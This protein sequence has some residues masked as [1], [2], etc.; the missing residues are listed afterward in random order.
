MSERVRV[1]VVGGGITGLAAALRL[2]ETLGAGEVRLL[3]SENRAG[4]K[5]TTDRVDGLVIEGGPDCFLAMKP[6]GMSLCHDLGLDE[7]VRGTNPAYRRTYIQRRGQLHRLPEGLSGL[8][9]SKIGPLLTTGLLSPLGR[10]RAG[11]EMFV[12]RAIPDDESIADFVSRRFGREAY[13]WLVEPLLSGIFAGD[14]RRLSLAATFP[15]LVQLEREH[16]SI[17]RSM[18]RSR[19]IKRSKRPAGPGFVTTAGGLAE[20]VE[21]AVRRLPP[22]TVRTGVRVAAME[23][24]GNGYQLTFQG[25]GALH[26]DRVILATPAYASAAV[27]RALHPTLADELD[28][29]PYVTSATVSLAYPASS[30][31]RPLD[32]YGY[33]SPRAEGGPVVACTWTSNKFPDRVPEGQVLVRYFLGRAGQEEIVA[34]D[35]A[36]LLDVARGEL[37]RLSG[38]T[39]APSVARVFRW[40]RGLPQ[41]HIGHRARLD[42]IEHA[43]VQLPGVALAGAAYRGVGIPDCITQGRAA[44]DRVLGAAKAAVAA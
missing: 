11:L 12:P 7:R 6:G 26:A 18:M 43:L 39:A 21:A 4:G 16:G 40:P 20:I 17:V 42:R 19:L 3:E 44:A 15:Q 9:P 29:I 37:R 5:I 2:S 24:A 38:I 10:I 13:D 34:Q 22:G 23:R 25:G 33:V 8:V 36:A 41:Y 31:P 28:A 30:V 35:D 14:G 27:L 1:A 32:G